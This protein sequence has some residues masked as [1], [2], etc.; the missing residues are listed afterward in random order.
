MTRRLPVAVLVLALAGVAVI[1]LSRRES[2][3]RIVQSAP[4]TPHAAPADAVQAA[5]P[6]PRKASGA[7]LSR[8][9]TAFDRF[10]EALRRGDRAKALEALE[11]LRVAF[12]PAPVPEAEN[13]ASIYRKAFELYPDGPTDE[14][15]RLMARLSDGE[16]LTPAERAILERA[17]EKNREALALLHRAA[18]MP[19][20]DFGVDFSKGLAAEL[21]HVAPMIRSAKLL[22]LEALLS[23]GP[24]AALAALASQRM[25][26]AVAEEPILIS[27]FVRAVCHGLASNSWEQAFRGEVPEEALRSL[28]DSLSPERAREGYERAFL[29]ELYGGAKLILEGGDLS[30][31]RP[32]AA[33]I[34]RP[35]DPLTAADLGYYAETMAEFS[36]LAG[37]PYYEARDRLAALRVERLDGAPWY[38]ELTR[39]AMPAFDRAARREAESEAGQ[40]ALR[41]AAA[42][43]IYRERHGA[44]PASL[45]ALGGL[46]PAAPVDP[47]TG[48]PYLYRREGPG[49]VV[50]S[51]GAD[52]ADGG[53]VSAES[54]VL[55]RSPR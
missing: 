29:F 47:F 6:V 34:R 11:D 3:P 7:A 42:L 14:E 23:E 39:L 24:R 38:A 40:G 31:F 33:R 37:R 20:C 12:T 35:D 32:E 53:G 16:A 19:R 17:L 30:A 8:P 13:A 41:L 26:E 1:V 28:L 2:P 25:A 27:Q 44:Y 10:L 15:A 21:P 22:D 55:F 4:S 48:R 49:F 18:S 45:D 46:L 52:G 9:R 5:A 54:D 43:R 50:W 36:A 51:V